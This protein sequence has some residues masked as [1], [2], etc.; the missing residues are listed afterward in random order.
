MFPLIEFGADNWHVDMAREAMDDTSLYSD[1]TSGD[2]DVL[3]QFS[4]SSLSQMISRVQEPSDAMSPLESGFTVV[5]N[6]RAKKRRI[7]KPRDSEDDY[8]GSVT[9]SEADEQWFEPR[10]IV[11]PRVVIVT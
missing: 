6:K 1:I 8:P 9:A 2:D 10:E 7:M 4:R 11:R 3:S 5:G